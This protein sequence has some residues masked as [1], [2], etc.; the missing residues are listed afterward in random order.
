MADNMPESAAAAIAAAPTA[1]HT[2]AAGYRAALAAALHELRSQRPSKLTAL[3]R[4]ELLAHCA[5]EMPGGI[6][7]PGGADYEPCTG[8]SAGWCHN[9]GD[10]ACPEDDDDR[11]DPDCPLHA[12]SSPHGDGQ[13]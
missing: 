12:A 10:C 1:E 5:E 3:E 8:I 2:Y 13:H 7:A 4:I 9:C 11:C 6:A